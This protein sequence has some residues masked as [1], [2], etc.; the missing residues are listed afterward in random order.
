MISSMLSENQA[1]IM[2]QVHPLIINYQPQID[3]LRKNFLSLSPQLDDFRKTTDQL[4][5]MILS[6]KLDLGKKEEGLRGTCNEL[7]SILK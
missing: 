3:E 4:N 7:H 6:L 2:T 5:E 1:A